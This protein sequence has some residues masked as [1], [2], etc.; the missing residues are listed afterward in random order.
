V[1]KGTRCQSHGHKKELGALRF[2]FLCLDAYEQVFDVPCNTHNACSGLFQLLL[3][4]W[5]TCD[6]NSVLL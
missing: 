5:L 3:T 6:H 2:V 1:L 4:M